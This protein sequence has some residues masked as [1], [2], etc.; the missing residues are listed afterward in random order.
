LSAVAQK[1]S[2]DPRL[3]KLLSTVRRVDPALADVGLLCRKLKGATVKEAAEALEKALRDVVLTP[4]DYMENLTVDVS[5]TS[6]SL[7]IPGA[8]KKPLTGVSI[9]FYP[10][11]KPERQRSVVAALASRHVYNDLAITATGWQSVALE[12]MPVE[13]APTAP[14]QNGYPAGS[15]YDLR[16]ALLTGV[17]DQLQRGILEQIMRSTGFAPKP[18][19]FAPKPL[20][21]APKP[22][23]FA[24]KP[25]GF[26]SKPLGFAAELRLAKQLG[27]FDSEV[28]VE[29]VAE[30][31]KRTRHRSARKKK[32]E[33]VKG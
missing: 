1:L 10:P 20:G 12:G 16:N 31:P 30:R 29:D 5:S 18:L 24:P 14:Y 9:F 19:G 17:L 25:L 8:D 15:E 33:R 32:K 11:T 3:R 23:G 22:L 27:V 7:Q 13:T 2:A 21:F 6:V 28:P 26:A 4:A